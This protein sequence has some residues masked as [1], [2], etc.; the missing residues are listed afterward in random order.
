MNMACAGQARMDRGADSRSLMLVVASFLAFVL[1][2]RPLAAQQAAAAAF[3]VGHKVL[4][5]SRTQGDEDPP[6][7]TVALWYPTQAAPSEHQYND[8][9]KTTTSVAMDA[10]PA[11][12]PHPLIVFSHGYG[13]AGI[14]STYLTEYLASQGFVVAAPDHEDKNVIER[15]KS[16]TPLRE[17]WYSY[18]VIKLARSG[19]HFH[20]AAYAQRSKDV[21]RVI[22]ELLNLNKTEGSSF[23]GTLNPDAIG[24]AGHSLGGYTALRV[25]GMSETEND[26]R[27][28]AALLLSGGVFMFKA[29]DYKGLRVPVMMMYGEAETTAW[30][31]WFLNNKAADT[32]RAYD[33]CT[34]PK[35]MMEIKGANHFSFCQA[36]FNKK[37]PGLGQEKARPAADVIKAYSL[38]F[39]RRWL[40]NDPKADEVLEATSP[41][42][43]LYKKQS[44]I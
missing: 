41:L 10:A 27:V 5:V 36:I 29:Q 17:K 19:K 14:A 22:D 43:L 38:A 11:P 15:T 44:K 1:Y 12:G 26:P 20:H 18:N 24:V 31:A 35:Y 7:M 23:R 21:T 32:Q 42:F 16:D 33:N 4:E 34:V 25:C 9:D 30:R 28:K 3:N 6:P 2:C 37:W 8:P 40:L 39:F 13:G